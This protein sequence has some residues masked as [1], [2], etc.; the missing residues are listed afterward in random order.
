MPFIIEPI[1]LI[2]CCMA[3][4]TIGGTVI[5]GMK[6]G[7]TGGIPEGIGM[8]FGV[9]PCIIT[10]DM[11]GTPLCPI[12]DLFQSSKAAIFSGDATERV[13]GMLPGFAPARGGGDGVGEGRIILLP[14]ATGERGVFA[15][16]DLE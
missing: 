5:P 9:P 10:G 16:P 4:F 2:G 6:A 14:P 11:P 3:G 7:L 15:A 8:L 13:A 12:F 1:G